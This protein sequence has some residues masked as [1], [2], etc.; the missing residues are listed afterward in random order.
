MKS[1]QMFQKKIQSLHLDDIDSIIEWMD[2]EY[3]HNHKENLRLWFHQ[4]LAFQLIMK[5]IENGEKLHLLSYKPR[6]GKT[7]ILLYICKELLKTKGRI[8]LMTSVMPDEILKSFINE[9]H[10]LIKVLLKML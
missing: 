1:F 9:I 10:K 8:L 7:L 6:S 4:L 2:N 5:N 3:L